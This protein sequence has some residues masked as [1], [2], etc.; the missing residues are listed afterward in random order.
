MYRLKTNVMGMKTL[1]WTDKLIKFSGRCSKFC[2]YIFLTWDIWQHLLHTLDTG[3][4]NCPQ[5]ACKTQVS[6]LWQF[7]L[8]IHAGT[9]DFLSW[10][11]SLALAQHAAKHTLPEE[12]QIALTPCWQ[13]GVCVFTL[14]SCYDKQDNIQCRRKKRQTP[15][16]FLHELI[17]RCLRDH[18]MIQKS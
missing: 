3:V 6:T 18:G 5:Q 10:C 16:I 11:S 13:A 1:H 2:S 4:S 15:H 14:C 7:V 12:Q 17:Q 8:Y 9:L